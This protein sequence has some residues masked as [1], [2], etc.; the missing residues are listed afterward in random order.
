MTK[1]TKLSFRVA[2]DAAG[3]RL[4]QAIAHSCEGVSRGEAR[5]LLARGSVFVEGSRVKVAG[6][7]VRS[8][9]LVEVHPGELPS[10]RNTRAATPPVAVPVL[11]ETDSLLVIDKPSG[12]PAAPTPETDQ[13][14]VLHFLRP[15]Y[16]ELYLVHRLDVPTSGAMVVARNAGAAAALSAQLVERRLHRSYVAL[17]KGE[18]AADFDAD[19]PVQGRPARSHFCVL[20]TRGLA[21]QHPVT[22]VRVELDT[23]R[24]HQIRVHAARA[25]HPVLGDGRYGRTELREWPRPP[26]LALHAERLELADPTTLESVSIVA[27]F[28][29][30]LE[31]FWASLC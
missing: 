4:D 1:A 2:S 16:G 19:W 22:R 6:R 26:R 7:V 12:V 28:P 27:P 11:L 8:G 30:A 24:T 18:V 14:D 29:P 31:A 15:R 13:N 21:A 17:V 10:E 25:G 9:Q 3:L 23:G 5:R 20:E